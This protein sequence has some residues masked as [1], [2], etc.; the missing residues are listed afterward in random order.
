MAI[1][2]GDFRTCLLYTSSVCMTAEYQIDTAVDISIKVLRTMSQQDTVFQ[3]CIRD[4]LHACL[5]SK[6][7]R[8]FRFV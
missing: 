7:D 8:A 5:Q 6:H 2:A 1:S 3:M 4:S